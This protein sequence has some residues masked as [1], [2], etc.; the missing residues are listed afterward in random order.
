MVRPRSMKICR[1]GDPS[2][3]HSTSTGFCD[4]PDTFCSICSQSEQWS[5]FFDFHRFSVKR[6][7]KTVRPRSVKNCRHVGLSKPHCTSMVFR[8]TPPYFLLNLL[9]KW[10]GFT[11]RIFHFKTSYFGHFY[12]SATGGRRRYVFRLSIHLSICLSIRPS[13][14]LSVRPSIHPCCNTFVCLITLKPLV[15]ISYKLYC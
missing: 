11:I 4:T 13:V 12:A 10:A 7:T 3:L 1:H 9:L 2:K 14:C 8:D 5:P 15:E 6:S